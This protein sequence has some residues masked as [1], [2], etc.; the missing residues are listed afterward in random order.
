MP[1]R[2]SSLMCTGQLKLRSPLNIFLGGQVL[3]RGVTLAGLIGFYYG[4]RP[5]K[6]QQDTVLQHSRMYGFLR[7]D[8]A[9]TRF[10]TSNAIR[11]AMSQM[12]EFDASLRAAIESGG[13]PPGRTV[14]L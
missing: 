1:G 13:D 7:R 3:D 5:N 6:Y 2:S 10:Y 11:Y 9:V 14:H 12:E 4:R 8:L